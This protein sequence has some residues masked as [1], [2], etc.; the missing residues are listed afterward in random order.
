MIQGE[1]SCIVYYTYIYLFCIL[2]CIIFEWRCWTIHRKFGCIIVLFCI[3]LYYVLYGILYC[4]SLQCP[5]RTEAH[6]NVEKMVGHAIWCCIVA[7]KMRVICTGV[8]QN[9]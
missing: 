3:I 5:K 9:A 6:K 1:A 4:P 2:L 7:L 8:T